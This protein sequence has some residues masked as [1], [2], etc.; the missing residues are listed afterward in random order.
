MLSSHRFPSAK[1]NYYGS[2]MV[3]Q[4]TG[5]GACVIISGNN[6][7][8]F[9]NKNPDSLGE[10]YFGGGVYEVTDDEALINDLGVK[11]WKRIA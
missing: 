4:G 7:M 10:W 9:N 2:E 5:H 1:Y 8:R 3:N 11:M 6:K